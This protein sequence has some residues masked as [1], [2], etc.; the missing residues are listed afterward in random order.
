MIEDIAT[1]K[2]KI[3]EIKEKYLFEKIEEY[4]LESLEHELVYCTESYTGLKANISVS[5]NRHNLFINYSDKTLIDIA[6]RTLA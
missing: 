3:E 4:T 1:Y 6:R 5:V 2:Q